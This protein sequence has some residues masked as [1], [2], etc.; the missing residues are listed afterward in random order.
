MK[1]LDLLKL[2]PERA[3]RP[4]RM[5][6]RQG[7]Y[8]NWSPEAYCLVGSE[9]FDNRPESFLKITVPSCRKGKVMKVL[10]FRRT[11]SFSFLLCCSIGSDKMLTSLLWVVQAVCFWAKSWTT[12]TPSWKNGFLGCWR[13]IFVGK[14]KL[15][16]R[17]GHFIVLMMGKSIKGSC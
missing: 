15:C 2:L 12:S 7:I 5:Y 10:D 11:W 8:L 1:C 16:W 14:E 4:N 17:N 3:L 6:W 13:S 9:A